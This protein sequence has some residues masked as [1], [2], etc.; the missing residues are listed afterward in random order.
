MSKRRHLFT[1]RYANL[2]IFRPE[3]PS[4]SNMTAQEGA[5]IWKTYLEPLRARGIRLGSPAP[6]GAPSGKTWLQ[7]FMI[8]CDGGCTF[9]FLAIRKLYSTSTPAERHSHVADII[10]LDWYGIDAS[11]FITF[12]NEYHT[13]FNKPIWITEWAC[14]NFD[15]STAS[16]QCSKEAVMTFM[17]R[18]QIF[19]DNA[20]FVE[21]Y[22]WFG[23]MRNLQGVNPVRAL[24]AMQVLS[25]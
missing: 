7:N 19:M 1:E 24:E 25:D 14:H 16:K 4:Q 5:T 13:T 20:P 9:D 23:A 8:S 6:A 15:P 18:T 12:L 17:N 3:Q 2:V 22:A 10:I 21:R 11:E